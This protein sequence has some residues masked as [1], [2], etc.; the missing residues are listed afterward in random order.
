MFSESKI[1]NIKVT[2]P[3]VAAPLSSMKKRKLISVLS[4]VVVLMMDGNRW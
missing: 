3:L 2:I 1:R 4:V